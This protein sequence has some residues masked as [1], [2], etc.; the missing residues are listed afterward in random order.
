MSSGQTIFVEGGRVIDPASGTDGVR[1]VVVREGRIAEVAERVERP[2]DA[3]SIDARG[4]WVTPGFIDLHAH[5]REPGHEYKET[6]QTGAA[7][8]VAGGFTAVCTMPNTS[9]VNDGAAVTDLIL[10]RA[11]AAGL[12]RVYPVGCI[13]KGQK[14]EELANFG[15]LRAS[16]CVAVTDDGRPV[17]SSALMRRA[18]E[19]AQ[20]F[21]L[22][23]SVH[24]EDLVLVGKGVMHEGLVSTRLGLKGA[25]GAAEDV[26]VLRD[27]ALAELTGGR[28]HIAHISSGG[29]VRAV[30]EA[31]RRGLKVTAEVTPHHLTLCDED[32][33]RSGYDS[34]FKMCPPLRSR[35]DVQA[36]R[37][38]LA[39][40]TIDCIATDHAPHGVIEKEIEF[41]LAA[42]GI[43]GLETAFAVCAALVRDGLISEARL[44][45]ALSAAPA[46]VFSLPG[47][48]LARGAPADVAVVDPG[49]EWRCDPERF[50]SKSRNSP[51]KGEV[52]IGRCTHTLVGGRLVYDLGKGER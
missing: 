33:E 8:A 26:M 47:G 41:D 42:N 31:R 25:P 14:G 19:Y 39:D 40:G 17:M 11:A 37:E 48:S 2:R 45:D 34:C 6:I 27:L 5:L 15:E 29:A 18:L 35:G 21:D 7:A 46:R 9:P 30:R 28:L 13:S 22:P 10:T 44:V 49:L 43:V 16:G 38:G 20:A 1:T 50:R 36:C 3:L 23:V 4:R 52:L 24:E 51:W 32:V 12:A